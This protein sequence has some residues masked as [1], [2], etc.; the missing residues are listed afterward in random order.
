M[1]IIRVIR[2]KLEESKTQYST[3]E[4][5]EIVKIELDK[6]LGLLAEQIDFE[7]ASLYGLARRKR[8]LQKMCDYGDGVN[9]IDSVRF[10]NGFGLSA[11]VAKKQKPIYLSDIHRGS[12]H[13]QAPIRS[14]LSMPIVADENVIG[15]LNL[16][17]TEAN[18]FERRE[19]CTIKTF[20][21]NLKPILE[22]Y[23]RYSYGFRN[24]SESNF[25]H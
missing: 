15:V 23:Q 3:T 13:G 18:A 21:E 16:A 17:H 14:Y 2:E 1:D 24:I 11:W 25:T 19:M 12:R 7:S 8:T 4:Y 22:I 9:F 6:C 5:R 20:I 10:E